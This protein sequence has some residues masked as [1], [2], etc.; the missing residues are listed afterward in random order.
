MP[1]IRGRLEGVCAELDEEKSR[2]EIA[3]QKQIA[4]VACLLR[5]ARDGHVAKTIGDGLGIGS[6]AGFYLTNFIEAGAEALF[7]ALVGGL[8]VGAAGEIV[9]EA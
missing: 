1:R 7:K 3:A 2:I 8:V 9:G 4:R 6:T 5:K